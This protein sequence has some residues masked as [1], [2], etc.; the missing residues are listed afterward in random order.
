ML[1]VPS[2]KPNSVQLALRSQISLWHM[3]SIGC[4]V[5]CGYPC[6]VKR[7]RHVY[8]LIYTQSIDTSSSR[9]QRRSYVALS[10]SWPVVPNL[11]I[12]CAPCYIHKVRG[13]NPE[14]PVFRLNKDPHQKHPQT[15]SNYVL[16]VHVL[17]FHNL[18]SEV[19]KVKICSFGDLSKSR[20]FPRSGFWKSTN[21][22][23]RDFWG[24]D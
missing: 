21:R 11:Q 10:S 13:S 14:M 8:K 20:F 3:Q 2:P 15:L 7:L 1:G 16:K 6:T 23:D 4:D 22:S 24:H 17:S 5:R 9:V 12:T 19:K 18:K